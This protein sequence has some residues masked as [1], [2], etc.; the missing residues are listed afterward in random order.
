[1]IFVLTLLLSC[2]SFIK[3][4]KYHRY[5]ILPNTAS[6]NN[7]SFYHEVKVSFQI[8][9]LLQMVIIEFMLFHPYMGSVR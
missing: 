8:L 4:D 7:F 6:A 2:F 3:G 9:F 5:L 1:M